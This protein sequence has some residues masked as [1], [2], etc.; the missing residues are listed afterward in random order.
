MASQKRDRPKSTWIKVVKLDM[1]RRN[2]SEDLAQD[3]S[4]WKNIIHVDD[5]N[6]VETR[7]K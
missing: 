3:R 2:L 7:P 5:P 1:K 4:K 6:I